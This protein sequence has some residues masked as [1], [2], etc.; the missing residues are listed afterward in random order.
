MRTTRQH[1]LTGVKTA[2]VSTILGVPLI[3]LLQ[4]LDLGNILVILACFFVGSIGGAYSALRTQLRRRKYI[5][6][7]SP[8]AGP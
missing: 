6:S 3:P 8:L 4:R 5:A 7:P 2:A 1:L